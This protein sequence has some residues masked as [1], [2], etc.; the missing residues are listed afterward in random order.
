[1]TLIPTTLR[2]VAPPTPLEL[3]RRLG[4]TAGE[5]AGRLHDLGIRGKPYEIAACPLAA[6]LHDHGY[7]WFVSG[8]YATGVTSGTIQPVRLPLACVDF[9]ERFDFGAYPDLVEP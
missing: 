2:P 8:H 1:M 5:V 3:L 9:V 4:D 6:Y 7:R